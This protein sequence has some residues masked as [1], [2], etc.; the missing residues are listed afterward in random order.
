VCLVTV[1][2]FGVGLRTLLVVFSSI[3]VG[4]AD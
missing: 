4:L 2:P 3:H 1:L